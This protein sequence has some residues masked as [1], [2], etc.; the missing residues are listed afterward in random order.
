MKTD[1]EQEQFALA[2][3]ENFIHT[4][5]DL[6]LDKSPPND[7]CMHISIIKGEIYFTI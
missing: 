6:N 1:I 2:I 7:Q 3:E 5:L 4:Y